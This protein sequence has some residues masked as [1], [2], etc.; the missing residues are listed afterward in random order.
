MNPL[1]NQL[2]MFHGLSDL[3]NQL[4]LFDCDLATRPPTIWVDVTET[5]DWAKAVLG[6]RDAEDQDDE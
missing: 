4:D 3:P 5:P 6:G 1:P 2:P